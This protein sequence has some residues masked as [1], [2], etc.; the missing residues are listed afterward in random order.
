MVFCK[1]NVDLKKR[2][3]TVCF[4]P[5]SKIESEAFVLLSGE[6]RQERER[7]SESTFQGEGVG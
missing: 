3:N 6:L 1:A 5:V 7:V 4:P 2:E